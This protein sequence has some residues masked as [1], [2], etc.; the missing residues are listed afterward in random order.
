MIDT[1]NTTTTRTRLH[2]ILACALV[3]SLGI[4]LLDALISR[5]NVYYYSDNILTLRPVAVH[6]LVESLK[7]FVRPLEYLVVLAANN[8]YLPLWLGASLLCTV[9]ATIL[10]ALACEL[11]FERELPKA[12]WRVLGLANPILFYVT[13]QAGVVSQALSNVLFA[14][15]LFAF[16]V[17]LRW[18]PGRSPSGWRAERVSVFLNIMAAAMFFA[19]ETAV[20][21]GIVLPAV[22]AL[23]RLRARRLSPIF[24]FSLLLP[25]AA[26]SFWF[27]LKLK[28][29]SVVPT[30]TG[31]GRYDLT[32]NPIAWGENLIV[33]LAFPLTPLP[34]SFIGFE[35][36]RPLWVTIALGSVTLFM[37]LL[38]R[39]T[40]YQP[41]IVLPLLVVAASLAPMI[42]V[43][44]SELYATMIAPF[45]VAIM[46]LFGLSRMRRLTIVYGLVLYASSLVNGI[47]Y[48]L[49]S[50]FTLLGLPHLQ[51]SI[52]TKEYQYYPI[53]PIG[54]TAHVEWDGTAAIDVPLY[55]DVKGAVICIQ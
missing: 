34:T 53:C 38:L 45:V 49:G 2:A 36:L 41:R 18:V 24:L 32:L 23:I 39:E 11:V 50:D 43:R 48:M 25:V 44:S 29:P 3:G 47:I 8:V 5:S 19:K 26:A 51:Y 54:T 52:Y 4:L 22:T 14:G 37:G 21:A 13:S 28:F 33:T 27:L 42:F 30:P 1:D 9:G 55:S 17:E 7:I 35:L 6:S 12:G 46:I 15:A 40:L 31:G 20:A 10:S 16:A